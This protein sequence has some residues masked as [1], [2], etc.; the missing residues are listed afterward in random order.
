LLTLLRLKVK[1]KMAM[2]A[3]MGMVEMEMVGMEIQMRM[4]EVLGLLLENVHTRTS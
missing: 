2:M 3:I 4:V 1:A